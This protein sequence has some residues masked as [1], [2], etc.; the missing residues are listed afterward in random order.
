[1]R[2]HLNIGGNLGENPYA[3]IR[4][5]IDLTGLCAGQILAVSEPV[6]SAAWGFDSER[7][8][9]NV[10]VDLS[11]ELRPEE[12]LAALQEVER[13]VAPADRHRTASGG[14]ADRRVDIDIIAMEGL[15]RADADPLLPHP[16]MHLRE[17]VL[18][19]MAELWPGWRHPLM[20]GAT[21]ADLLSALHNKEPRPSV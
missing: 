15:V 5:A 18:R 17:F 10:G 3:D 4:K 2:A 14:Y 13:R 19:P 7:E 16:R 12:L 11:T 9:V 6:R 1:M 20:G 8:F 21:A